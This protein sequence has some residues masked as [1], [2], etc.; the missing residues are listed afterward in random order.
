[1]PAKPECANWLNANDFPKAQY[2]TVD[3]ECICGAKLE[4][5]QTAGKYVNTGTILSRARERARQ[6]HTEEGESI[7]S[8][9]QWSWPDPATSGIDQ[10]HARTLTRTTRASPRS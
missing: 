7:G 9:D 5:F 2:V 6:L 4:E 1:M 3:A 10:Y 8:N